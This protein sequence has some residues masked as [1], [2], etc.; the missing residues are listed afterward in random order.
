MS[1]AYNTDLTYWPDS[2]KVLI[3]II[4]IP[5][6]TRYIYPSDIETEVLLLPGTLTKVGE[7]QG[8]G[9]GI[10]NYEPLICDRVMNLLK[11]PDLPNKSGKF[12]HITGKIRPKGKFNLGDRVEIPVPHDLDRF[13]SYNTKKRTIYIGKKGVIIGYEYKGGSSKYLV[14]FQNGQIDLFH[15]HFIEKV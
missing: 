11:T 8:A 14:D 10:F 12:S 3:G 7:F 4:N 15:S 13:I 6:G 1:T 9:K 2:V 5:V